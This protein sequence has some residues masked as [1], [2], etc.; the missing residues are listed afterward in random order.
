MEHF[1][2]YKGKRVKLKVATKDNTLD[3][4]EYIERIGIN[5]GVYIIAKIRSTDQFI[6]IR[7]FRPALNQYCTAFPAGMQDE[8]ES[9]TE[10]AIRE[11][12]EETGYTLYAK[13]PLIILGPYASCAGLTSEVNYVCYGYVDE[14][15][16]KQDQVLTSTEAIHGLEVFEVYTSDFESYLKGDHGILDVKTAAHLKEIWYNDPY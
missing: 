11:F 3:G 4:W 14:I 2:L 16:G 10:T 6:L 7:Q 9:P 5:S 12:H 13:I 15:I 1:T 8:G